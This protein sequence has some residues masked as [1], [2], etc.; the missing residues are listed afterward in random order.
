MRRLMLALSLL[1]ACILARFT[2]IGQEI[3]A[4]TPTSNVAAA[5]DG[6]SVVPRLIRYRGVISPQLM[7]SVEPSPTENES[8]NTAPSAAVIVTFSIYEFQEGG[9]PLWSESQ[10]VQVDAQ[11][12]YTVLL[13][14][15]TPGGLPLDLFA[16]GVAR[17]LGTQPQLSGVGEQPRVLL[18]SVPYALKAG[19]AETLGGK[20]ASAYI[21]S[22]AF[23]AAATALQSAGALS[24]VPSRTESR[25]A[26]PNNSVSVTTPGGTVKQ[27][28]VFDGTADI[29]NSIIFDNGTGVGIGNTSPGG[30]LDVS[31]ITII[32]GALRL[33]ATGAATSSAGYNSNP[34]DLRASAF[35]GSNAV[36]RDFLWVA[37][38]TNN[39][40]L[41]A[42]ATLNLQFGA[43][44]A[45]AS[46]TG[47]SIAANG[48]ITFAP[49]QTF[50]AA[51]T[52]T[53][54]TAGAG[55]AGGGAS[56]NITLNLDTTE[57]ADSGSSQQQLR[58]RDFGPKLHRQRQRSDEP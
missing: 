47:L 57:G 50:P 16:S 58:G 36:S 25:T 33:P 4:A 35:D 8:Q 19:D 11:G 53:Q 55:L 29:T 13:G 14:A 41:N 46:E 9:A 54:V 5:P 45:T 10:K 17:W 48:I 34:L 2:A 30:T 15:N 22:D 42:S 40:S 39:N 28:A 18:L 27:L 38:P 56:G 51:G 49:N 6:R 31:G 23:S 1:P 24:P 21:T 3:V 32:E 52:I 20:P 44:G 43:N 12:H 37:E 7:K 26:T